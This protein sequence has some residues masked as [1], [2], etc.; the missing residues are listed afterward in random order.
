[1]AGLARG[2]WAPAKVGAAARPSSGCPLTASS[3]G[4]S[5]LPAFPVL[6]LI[7]P[8]VFREHEE[9][10]LG[11]NV[12]KSTTRAQLNHGDSAFPPG[13]PKTPS[14]QRQRLFQFKTCPSP[15]SLS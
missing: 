15:K 2:R 3:G 13:L 10:Q 6:W 4:C 9:L 5:R 14:E 12:H 8:F 1:M 7:T 11:G